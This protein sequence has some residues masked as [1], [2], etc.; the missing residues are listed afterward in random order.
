MKTRESSKQFDLL[1]CNRNSI[2]LNFVLIEFELI[3][4]T[5]CNQVGTLLSPDACGP[6]CIE[7]VLIPCGGVTFLPIMCPHIL[8]LCIEY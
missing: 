5:T 4:S 7:I 3:C 6:G 2:D 1:D 8:M